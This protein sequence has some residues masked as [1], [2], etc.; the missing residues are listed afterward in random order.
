MD[1]GLSFYLK[2]KLSVDFGKLD[3]VRIVENMD[4][5]ERRDLENKTK[6]YGYSLY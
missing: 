5:T 2:I 3:G 1:G 4:L 6:D